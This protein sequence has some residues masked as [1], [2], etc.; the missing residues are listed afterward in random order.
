MV[1]G[2]LLP[3]NGIV[4]LVAALPQSA[5]V[6]VILLVTRIAVLR[7][8]SERRNGLGPLMTL[9]ARGSCMLS[10]QGEIDLVMIEC[11]AIGV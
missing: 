8:S 4:A 10:L 7:S 1:E 6:F 2:R 3:V 5:L 9:T 11:L